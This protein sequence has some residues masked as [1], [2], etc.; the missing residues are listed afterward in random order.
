MPNA[1]LRTVSGYDS[2][3]LKSVVR[4]LSGF[5]PSII[6]CLG[7][8][9]PRRLVLVKPNWIQESHQEQP[10]VWEPVITHPSPARCD[11]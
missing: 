3:N 11:H 7:Q 5:A 10:E 8:A 1:R 2:P 6:E 4:E 9:D